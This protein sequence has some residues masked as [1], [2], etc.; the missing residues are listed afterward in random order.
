MAFAIGSGGLWTSTALCLAFSSGGTETHAA[1]TFL[2]SLLGE[3][4]VPEVIDTD[5]FRSYGAAIREI[6]ILTTSR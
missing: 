4:D 2:A 5:Q 1:K 6:P 3:Y